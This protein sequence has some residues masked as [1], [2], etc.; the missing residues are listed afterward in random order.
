MN[1]TGSTIE[2][3]RT[4][5]VLVNG[6]KFLV[7]FTDPYGYWFI[8]REHGQIPLLLSGAYTHFSSAKKAIE[9]YVS[10]LPQATVERKK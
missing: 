2:T 7:S 5:E 9:A 4:R 1:N 8:R 6:H 10:Q 3:D